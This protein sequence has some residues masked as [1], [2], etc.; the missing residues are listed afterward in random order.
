VA[1]DV[2]LDECSVSRAAERLHL[3]QPAVSAALARLRDYFQDDLLVLHGKRMIATAYAESLAPEVRAVL[4]RIDTLIA[5][6]SEFDPAASERRFSLIASDYICT[7]LLA[8]AMQHLQLAAPH[9]E[10]D[11]RLPNDQMLLEFDRGEVDLLMTPADYVLP[12]HP[13]ELLLEEQHVV[14]AWADNPNIGETLTQAEFLQAPH[15]VVTIGHNRQHTYAE[16]YLE[17]AIGLRHVEVFA[18]NFTLVPWLLIGTT[19]LAVMHE[20]LAHTFAANLPLRLLPLPVDVPP[21][22]EM[23][24]FH[25]ARSEDRGLRWL[26][27]VLR[28][29]AAGFPDN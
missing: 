18:P 20:R 1:L 6:S 13:T 29:V 4:G 16:P 23:L 2:L 28:R 19:R 3:S 26:R 27:E 10:V 15:V 17:K 12:G 25:S 5:M 8:P 24:Q 14:V 7:V 11:I 21:M 22:R 9:I